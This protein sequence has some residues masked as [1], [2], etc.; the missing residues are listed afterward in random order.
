MYPRIQLKR[1]TSVF[2]IALTCFGLTPQAWAVV[3]APDGGYPGGNTAEGQNALLSL[4]CGTYNAAVGFL[5]LSS[6]STGSFNTGIG[7][8]TLLANTADEN[9][10]TGA[11]ALLSNTNGFQNTANGAFALFSNTT[12]FQNTATSDVALFSNTTGSFNTAIG[13]NA[14]HFNTEGIDN[15]AIGTALVDNTT[16]SAN[17]AIGTAALGGNVTGNNNTALGS[18]AGSSI[19]GSGNVC[20]GKGVSGDA[21]VDDTTWIRNVYD[22]VAVTRQVYV[23]QDNKIGT[24]ASTRRVKDDIKPMDKVSETIFALKPVRFRYKKEI[25]RYR[26]PQFGLVA[27][28]VA[29][30]NP[31]L[32]TQNENGEVETVRYEAINAM[33]LNEFL[34]ERKKVE[35]QEATIA[36]LKSGMEALTAMVKE[37][38]SQIQKANARLGMSILQVTENNQ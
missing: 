20:I 38:A 17:T 12:G 36:E 9:T 19:D 14:L 22:S 2:L 1:V 26:A 11:G 10:A 35:Q 4:T 5:S 32:V 23:N 34:K 6:D 25:D 30:V 18:Q 16:G 3:P 13:R 24:L 27:E 29:Q 7:A 8:G 33:L 31:D 37:Q 15:V 28:D 21:G